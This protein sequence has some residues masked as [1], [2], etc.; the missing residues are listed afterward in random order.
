[1]SPRGRLTNAREKGKQI[2]K[3]LNAIRRYGFDPLFAADGAGG[4]GGDPGSDDGNGTDGNGGDGGD[5]GKGGK[6]SGAGAGGGDGEKNKNLDGKLFTEAELDA[7]LEKKT[8][9]IVASAKK[10]AED[11]IAEAQR[12]AQMNEDERAAEELK[13][14][15]AENEAFKR[16]AAL[17]DMMKV[18]RS[19]LREKGLTV[20]DEIITRLITPD[21]DETK[22]SINA[23][24]EMYA[25]D[26]DAGVKEALKGKTATDKQTGAKSGAGTKTKAEILAIEDKAE[27]QRLIQENIELFT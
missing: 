3:Y 5:G 12:L 26:V 22:E 4:T 23:F 14:L 2:M 25:A 18:A 13:K 27:R 9:R 11:A 21:A 24:A 6:Q 19:M 7:I 17:A 20:P 15:K 16:S 1:M 8:A 10:Q